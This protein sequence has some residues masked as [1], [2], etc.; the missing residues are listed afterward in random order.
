MD[1]KQQSVEEKQKRLDEEQERLD[2]DLA[3]LMSMADKMRAENEDLVH[4]KI[5][6]KVFRRL[7]FRYAQL[8]SLERQARHCMIHDDLEMQNGVN[9]T[10]SHSASASASAE[11]IE[12]NAAAIGQKSGG[13]EGSAFVPLPGTRAY[14]LAVTDLFVEKALAYLE[15]R[16]NS[17]RTLGNLTNVGALAVI[18]IGA[19]IAVC[20]MFFST[21]P[22][23]SSQNAGIE[24]FLTFA[25]SFTAYGMLVLISVG[26][27]RYGKAMLDQGERLLERRHALRQG[28]LFVHLNDGWLSLEQ[29]KEAFNWN[30]SGENAFGNI[31]TE[32]SAPW[33]AAL[34]EFMHQVPE[35]IREGLKVV[36]GK[37][38]KV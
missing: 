23:L 30:V 15:T 21:P 11:Q 27:S 16:A 26:L 1:K 32:A 18:V 37:M 19:V 36:S 2:A 6:A 13:T 10:S 28:R 34:K 5:A 38:K 3:E 25:R 9:G 33:G 22:K 20:Q 14:H 12:D 4:D 8:R 24:G 17:Y 29:M 31:P 35:L 7:S